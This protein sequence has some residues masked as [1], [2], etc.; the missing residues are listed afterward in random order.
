MQNN[1]RKQLVQV[2]KRWSLLLLYLVVALFVPFIN[3]THT[4]EYWILTAIPL[5]AYVGCGF[6]Y[7]VKRWLP[8]AVHW[9]M[10]V[11][12]VV[13]SYGFK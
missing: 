10:V 3:A 9:L 2:R 4:F 1:F 8:V 13:I 6:L 11:V 12:V 5:A 7:P